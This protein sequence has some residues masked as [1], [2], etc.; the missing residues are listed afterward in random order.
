MGLGHKSRALAC[1]GQARTRSRP[2][3]PRFGVRAKTQS[4]FQV[5]HSL[6][7]QNKKAPCLFVGCLFI[8]VARV[9]GL[10]PTTFRVTGGRS[11]QTELQP[12]LMR[13][14]GSSGRTRTCDLTIN[15]RVLYQLSYRGINFNLFLGSIFCPTSLKLRRAYFTTNL[16]VHHTK[17][18]AKYGGRYRTRTCDSRRVKPVLYQLS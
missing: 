16:L 18:Y 15:S 17:L 8:L 2:H 4:G 10:E 5:P 6:T 11:N 7:N 14:N 3:L 13:E 12:L 9:M 1:R